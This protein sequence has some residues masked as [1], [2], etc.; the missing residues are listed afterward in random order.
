[1]LGDDTPVSVTLNLHV[2]RAATD[3]PEDLEAKRQIDALGNEVFL[4]PMLE[5]EYPEDLLEDTKHITDW[6]FVQDG[7]LERS[8]RPIDV[9]G[10]NYYS[11]GRVRRGTPRS[12]RRSRPGRA[13]PRR[14]PVGRARR[15][16]SSSRSPA[17][18]RTWAGTSSPQ[19]LVDLLARD[20][21]ALPGPPADDHRERRRVRRRGRADG[22]V[23]DAERVDYLHDHIDA[24]GEAI[25][26][27]VD[28]RGYFVWS[29]MDNFEW[30]YG[31]SKRFG[32]VRVDYDTQERTVK[33]SGHWY[34]QLIA[35]N[36][37]PTTGRPPVAP[38]VTSALVRSGA[39]RARTSDVLGDDGGVGRRS[40][41][42]PYGAEHVEL[43]LDRATAGRTSESGADGEW[44]VQR[45]RGSDREYRCPGCDQVLAAGTAHVV[46]WRTDGLFGEALDDRRHWH[47]SC[48]QARGR[49][50]P[51]RR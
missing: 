41:K 8:S 7:D 48:W 4:G 3:A 27:G 44:T 26:A 22:A 17:R 37:I 40:T 19:G 21:R 30:S 42:R 51:T 49:R 25:D 45:V 35:T 20:A 38:P 18:T 16:S 23:H 47:T 15:T 11:T 32:I 6:S 24:V 31:Y 12:A 43:D 46:A 10:V 28:V 29:L 5:G 34:R 9:L 13:P 2:I 1:M 50:G 14:E 36:T 39:I 33:D